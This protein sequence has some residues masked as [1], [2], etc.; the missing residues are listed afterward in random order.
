MGQLP[1]SLPEENRHDPSL[2]D[3]RRS[4][5]PFSP[6][7]PREPPTTYDLEQ[8]HFSIV[9]SVSHMNMSYTY[10]MFR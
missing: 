6:Q 8:A 1:N 9:F 10:G 4:H 3:R 7:P 5:L 2:L